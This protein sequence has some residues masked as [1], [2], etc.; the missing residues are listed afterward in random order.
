MDIKKIFIEGRPIADIIQDLK[1]STL[2][3][4]SWDDLEK[5]YDP[6][7]HAIIT[8]KSRRP[9][10]KIRGGQRDVPAKI[11]YAAEKIATRRVAQ[12]AFSTPVKRRYKTADDETKK[13]QAKAMEAVYN[14]NRIDGVNMKR[15][16]AFFASCQVFTIWYTVDEENELYGF[17]SA[18]KL[19]CR[20]YSPMPQKMSGITHAVPY[21]LFDEYDDLQ[22]ISFQYSVRKDGTSVPRFDTYTKTLHYQWEQRGDKW[23]P[24]TQDGLPEPITILTHPISYWWRYAPFF[25]GVQN[26]RDEIEFSMSRGSDVIRKNIQPIV[27]IKGKLINEAE[28]PVG[29]KAR[30]VYHVEVGGDVTTVSP[31]IK[32]T[33]AK[34][35][36]DLMKENIEEETQMP[37]LTIDR[38]KGS[39]DSGAARETLLTDPHLRV[40]EEAHDILTGLHREGNVIKRFLGQMN[41][42]WEKTIM[43]LEVEHIITPFVQKDKAATVATYSQATGGKAIMSQQDAVEAAQLVEDTEEG[44]RRLKLEA[45]ED[46]AREAAYRTQD[47]FATA[48]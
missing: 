13:S 47:I 27:V 7:Q 38:I 19:K 45:D 30:E 17:K 20:S 26:N 31:A 35:H 40:M 11:T 10:D 42:S 5:D 44:L 16:K 46:A 24:T 18:K 2:L 48:Q 34:L 41:K 3:V 23:E 33:D 32:Q 4:P 9:R 22:V 15:F 6:N 39:G 21:V 1:Q 25:E 43:Q 36:I 28:V 29:D 14:T 37:N 8:D 12:M